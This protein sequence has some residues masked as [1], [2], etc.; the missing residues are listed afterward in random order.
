MPTVKALAHGRRSAGRWHP[1]G[2]NWCALAMPNDC[3]S[4]QYA[5]SAPGKRCPSTNSTTGIPP[6]TALHLLPAKTKNA[7]ECGYANEDFYA[8]FPHLYWA[9]TPLPGRFLYVRQNDTAKQKDDQNDRNGTECTFGGYHPGQRTARAAAHA[10]WASLAKPSGRVGPA[11]DH[12]GGCRRP[13]TGSAELD[14]SPG[15]GGALRG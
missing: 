15:G 12:A 5:L 3:Q 7:G 2:A 6:K 11:G 4:G 14:L 10:H 8:G 1:G 13:L 9:G